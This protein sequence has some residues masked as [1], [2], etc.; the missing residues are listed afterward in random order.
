M[1]E[2]AVIIC[3]ILA[4]GY[5]TI[6]PL[7]KPDKFKGRFLQ[8]TDERLMELNLRKEGAYATIKEL[9]FDMEMGK[10][11]K[12]VYEALKEQYTLEAV[13]SMKEI[14]KLESN[15]RKKRARVKKDVTTEIEREISAMRGRKT[16]KA[17]NLLCDECGKK[18]STED[19]FCSGCGAK[20]VKS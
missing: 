16:P 12:E 4:A 13:D 2:Y 3:S 11:S 20:L 15:K 6:H 7:L 10:L 14:D 5:F 8:T 1:L 9:E 18:A 19:R 17:A